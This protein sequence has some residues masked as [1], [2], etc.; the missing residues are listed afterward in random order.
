MHLIRP[1][2]LFW[3]LFLAFTLA[4]GT[5][6]L[7]GVTFVELTRPN[8]AP[9]VPAFEAPVRIAGLIQTQG[10]D[11]ALPLLRKDEPVG[12]IALVRSDGAWVAGDRSI[13]T[14]APG[15]DVT[16]ADGTRYRLRVRP[17]DPFDPNR[18]T[19]LLIGAFVSLFFSAGLAWYLA[20]PLT[21][22]SRGL[23]DVAMGK[24]TTRLHPLVGGRRDEIADLTHDF[25]SMAGQL[26]QLMAS[27]ER[28]LHDVSHELRSPLARL[29]VAI[30]LL[31]QAPENLP[32]MLSRVDRET[33]RLDRLIEEVLT[34]AR[35]KSG[36]ADLAVTQVDVVDLLIAIVDDANFEAQ[37]KGCEVRFTSAGPFVTL[38][39]GELLYRAYENVIRNAV[40]FSPEGTQIDV[41]CR[42][43]DDRLEVRI[44]DQGPGVPPDMLAEIFE[45]FKGGGRSGETDSVGFGLGLAIAKHAVER[46]RGTI[47]ARR[48]N[49]DRGLL[50]VIVIPVTAS[51]AP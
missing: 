26:Q 9:L 29:Q 43:E 34:L 19:P 14:N 41:R 1:G 51:I 10:I 32:A 40:K 38:A 3:K 5:S 48:G 17:S 24:L 8:A 49:G 22:L 39:Y 44:E 25:D 11:A 28:L 2:R 12:R 47:C 45:P 13:A 23:R 15:L 36:T 4:T 21:H 16:D 37:A 33:E 20:R 31:R 50:V 6:F 7:V 46:H 30:G 42:V 35:L 27:Q 18:T